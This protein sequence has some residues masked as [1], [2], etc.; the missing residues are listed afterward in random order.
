MSRT[1][2]SGEIADTHATGNP[3]SRAERATYYRH[4]AAQF[5]VLADDERS[6]ARRAKLAE[7]AQLYAALAV[8]VK[9]KP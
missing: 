1:R 3:R 5:Q 7:L 4:Y 2:A 8:R 6:K 9:T